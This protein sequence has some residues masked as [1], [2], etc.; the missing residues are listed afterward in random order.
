MGL[1]QLP[2]DT[3]SRTRSQPF[4][5]PTPESESDFNFFPT[6]ESK[7]QISKKSKYI[8]THFFENWLYFYWELFLK[9]DIKHKNFN[10]NINQPF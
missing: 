4:I 1:N 3:G 2:V 8:K 5:F 7:I 10:L 9:I 6:P